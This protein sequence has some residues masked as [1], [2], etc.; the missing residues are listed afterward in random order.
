MKIFYQII[1][2]KD[3]WISNFILIKI[4]N[5][6]I[7]YF[8]SL[9]YEYIAKRYDIEKI[10]RIYISG[11]GASWIKSGLE[12]IEK[13]VFVLDR[14]HINKYVLKST[15]HVP[16]LRFELW[17]AINRCNKKGVKK[18][19]NEALSCADSMSRIESILTCKK[20][21]LNNW[22]GIKIYKTDSENIIGCSA[23]GHISHVLSARLSSRPLGWSKEG[24]DK[25]ARLR[26]YKWNDGN[27]YELVLK[28]K[29]KERTKLPERYIKEIK[30]NLKKNIADINVEIPVIKYGKRN[31]SYFAINALRY[32]W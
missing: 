31:A 24:A 1:L 16:Q 32:A 6:V 4:F 8:A 20:Y 30:K 5:L 12:Y 17:D 9:Q 15:G 29:K 27:V 19:L 14:Y 23:E 3:I 2:G 7:I 28:N 11:D 25:M 13:S 22:D 26:A 18:V 21:L 10:K